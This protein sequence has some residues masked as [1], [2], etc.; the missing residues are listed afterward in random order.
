MA[1]EITMTVT[2]N[3][4]NGNLK[5]SFAPGTKQYNQTT[6]GMWANVVTVG[7]SEEDLAPA[8]I[9]TPGIL[10]AINLDST[11]YVNWGPKSGG[12]MVTAGQLKAGEMMHFRVG[13]GV[14]LR[15]AANTASV[16][17]LVWLLES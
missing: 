3:L 14:T 4:I 1:N 8:D 17:V 15:W 5:S 12:S 10:C 13:G 6:A 16:K 7:T 9:S 2:G 11:N